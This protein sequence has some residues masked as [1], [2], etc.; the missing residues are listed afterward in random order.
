MPP[1]G[2]NKDFLIGLVLACSSSVFIGSSFVFKKRGLLKL[3]SLGKRAGDGGYGYLRESLWWAGVLLMGIGEAANFAAYAFA[4]ASLVTPLGALSVLVTA[5]LSSHFLN[6]RL[7]LLGKLGCSICVI[8][9]TVIVLHAPKEQEVSSIDALGHKLLD[10]VFVVYVFTI[11]I[12]SLILVF[13]YQR[14]CGHTNVLVYVTIC[15]AIGSLSVMGCKGIGLAVKQ[16]LLGDNR[17]GHWL[18]WLLVLQV[19]FCITIQLVYLNRALDTFNTAVVTPVYYVLF[20]TFVIIASA[21]LFKEWFNMATADVVGSVCGFVT[22]VCGI[23]L[24]HAFRDMDIALDSLTT[25]S[26]AGHETD[27]PNS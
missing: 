9:S 16:T 12:V 11:A 3:A 19:A 15:S 21:V 27:V 10:P 18:F 7:N 1:E 20:T 5:V 24:L 8:G 17:I 2:D 14:R 4:P 13:Y 23:F 26:A 6:E 25:L 22:T